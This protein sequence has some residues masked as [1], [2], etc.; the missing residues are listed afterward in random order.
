MPK[1]TGPKTLRFEAPSNPAACFCEMCKNNKAFDL[2]PTIADSFIKG[3]VVLFVGAG[4]STEAKGLL[5]NSFYQ[6]I[7]HN[8]GCTD[9]TR[10]F[11]AVMHRYPQILFCSWYQD[12]LIHALMR[13]LR[14]RRLGTYS[15]LHRLMHS[16]QSY[17]NF[18]KRY[19]RDK[20]YS[21]SA[22]C[23]GYATAYLYAQVSEEHPKAKPPTFFYF[24]A[25]IV[26]KSIYK[27]AIKK[28]PDLH[29]GAFR[30]A[31]KI[32]SEYPKGAGVILHHIDQ[33]NLG[34]YVK[35]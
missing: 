15:D 6:E 32:V 3:E 18:A 1:A 22:Y 17:F 19:R 23:Y 9:S 25:E 16:Y 2:P 31:Q 21:D 26:G 12:G 7:S 13:I 28:L 35:D 27:K 14:L 20:K 11:P 8:I 10:P 34:R 24:D 5:P 29:K 33:L 4:V 30:Y